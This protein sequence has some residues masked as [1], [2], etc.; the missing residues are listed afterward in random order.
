MH[1]W[2]SN[3]YKKE[4]F[5]EPFLKRINSEYKKEIILKDEYKSSMSVPYIKWEHF[6]TEFREQ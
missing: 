4:D 3:Y 6:I 1:R 5:G 2:A